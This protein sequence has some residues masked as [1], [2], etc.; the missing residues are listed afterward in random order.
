MTATQADNTLIQIRKRVRRLTSSPNET[1]LATSEIDEYIN[2]FYT[3]DFVSAIKT[4]QLK[5]VVTLY[6][7]PNIDVYTLDLNTYQGIRSPV[8]CEGQEANL[9]KDRSQFFN[10]YPR[11]ATKE[12]PTTGNGGAT[13]TFTLTNIPFLRNQVVIGS[14]NSSGTPIK[15]IDDG[16]GNLVNA[17]NTAQNAGTVNY[18]TGAVSLDYSTIGINP[19][20]GE[21][22]VTWVVQ[23]SASRPLSILYWDGEITVRPVPDGIYKID[24]EAYMTPVQFL[25]TNDSPTVFQ[26]KDYIATGA[27]RKILQDRGDMEGEQYLEK[28]MIEQQG[29]V[30]ARQSVEEIGQRNATIYESSSR[31][32]RIG[33]NYGWY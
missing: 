31:G 19:A 14:V 32:P 10:V 8:F 12:I 33:S 20:N 5:D 3:L 26:W 17:D 22:I 28:L 11:Y 23:Y 13:Y 16:S 1:S 2:S 9:F 25:N 27:A 7:S 6:T 4:D 24:F 15:V 18:L 30:L 29:L 21:D